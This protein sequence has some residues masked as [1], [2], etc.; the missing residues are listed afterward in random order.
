MQRCCTPLQV[1]DELILAAAL[2]RDSS[3]RCIATAKAR[4]MPTT[5]GPFSY[6][7]TAWAV[8]C[9][10]TRAL[11]TENLTKDHYVLDKVPLSI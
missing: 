5:A 9:W 7:K 1:K 2:E 10:D 3:A 8:Y 4:K 11:H 6:V